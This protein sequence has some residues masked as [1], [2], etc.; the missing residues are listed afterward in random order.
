MEIKANKLIL[1]RV[2]E[3][4]Y[5]QGNAWVPMGAFRTKQLA[6]AL[7]AMADSTIQC[8]FTTHGDHA[9]QD[10]KTFTNRLRSLPPWYSFSGFRNQVIDGHVLPNTFV[11]TLSRSLP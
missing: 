7:D 6:E 3:L 11:G 5:S 4:I 2:N 8:S 1:N 9:E 10:T